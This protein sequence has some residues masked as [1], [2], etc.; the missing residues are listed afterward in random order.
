[1]E[2]FR[3]KAF[4]KSKSASSN[5]SLKTFHSVKR[6]KSKRQ[7]KDCASIADAVRSIFVSHLRVYDDPLKDFEVRTKASALLDVFNLEYHGQYVAGEPLKRC[8]ICRRVLD[9]MLMS[10]P[11]K[12]RSNL[13]DVSDKLYG[14]T[15]ASAE[16]FFADVEAAIAEVDDDHCRARLAALRNPCEAP[17]ESLEKVWYGGGSAAL[18]AAALRQVLQEP[19]C[20]PFSAPVEIPGYLEIVK[21]PLDVGTIVKR[22][23]TKPLWYTSALT[24][25]MDLEIVFQNCI[26]F[27][28]RHAAITQ[29]ALESRRHARSSLLAFASADA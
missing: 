26:V 2:D 22:L 24:V 23:E 11:P 8:Y 19:S 27:N 5:S 14:N 6:N 18:C 28:G 20:M 9:H 21:D 12:S 7:Y 1:M 25:L 15:Y 29:M 3:A 17:G 10:L 16:D 4:L 13:A